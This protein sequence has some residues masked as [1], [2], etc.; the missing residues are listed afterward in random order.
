M[1]VVTRTVRSTVTCN[2]LRRSFRKV[3]MQFAMAGCCLGACFAFG[4]ATQ[5]SSQPSIQYRLERLQRWQEEIDRRN[6]VH[7]SF[8]REGVQLIWVTYD[9]ILDEQSWRWT[10]DLH[11]EQHPDQ[12]PHFAVEPFLRL[13][14]KIQGELRPVNWPGD[15]KGL[16]SI[17]SAPEALEFVR[18]L[19]SKDTWYRF[20]SLRYV[21]AAPKPDDS[22]AKDDEGELSP[23][24]MS[25][26][27]FRH[28]RLVTPDV[29]PYQGCFR[30]RRS[31]AKV[32]GNSVA[33]VAILDETVGRD[34]DY[35][36]RVLWQQPIEPS[37]HLIDLPRFQ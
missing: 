30:I 25:E 15:L 31:V 32:S 1:S 19:S 11:D 29:I 16:V 33:R 6:R 22:G 9:R 5:P 17:N 10:R 37:E 26:R 36:V 13:A 28:L 21:E 20:P 35:T 18:L 7:R 3:A 12:M 23:A 2:D 24:Y 14:A 34:G 27:D 8:I 4:A